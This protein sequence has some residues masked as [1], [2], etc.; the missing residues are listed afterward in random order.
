MLSKKK[1]KVIKMFIL[2]R[3]NYYLNQLNPYSL[4]FPIIVM[5]A[6]E[7]DFCFCTLALGKKYRDLA[8]N[9]AVDLKKYAPGIFFVVGTDRVQ[10]FTNYDNAIAFRLY[11]EGILHCYNDKRTVIKECLKQFEKAIYIDAD[12]KITEPVPLSIDCPTG[13]VGCHKQMLPHIKQYRSKDVPYIMEIADKLDIDIDRVKWV[14]EALFMVKKDGG[15]EQEFLDTW[16]K[17]ARYLELKGI[18]SGEGNIMG[19]AAAKVGWDIDRTDSWKTLKHLVNHL[20]ASTQ[21]TPKS[22]WNKLEKRLGYHYRL[23]KNRLIALQDYSF[24]YQ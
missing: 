10:D 17:I 18:N 14:G 3:A 15:K 24:Y 13:I 19:L 23:N 21:K 22:L 11:Q 5:T 1:A 6:K 8:K 12:T 16:E 4:I 9:L 20:D 7:K 2:L